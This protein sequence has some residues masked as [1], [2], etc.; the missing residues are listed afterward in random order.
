M[1]NLQN[2]TL[3]LDPNIELIRKWYQIWKEKDW[4]ERFIFLW[5]SFNALYEATTIADRD[6]D[7]WKEF[8][9]KEEVVNIW[10]TI[11]NSQEFLDF[12]RYLKNRQVY[13]KFGIELHEKGWLYNMQKNIFY[14]DW[15]FWNDLGK[16]IGVIYRIRNNLFHGWKRWDDSDID[17]IK[18]ANKSFLV[19]LEKLYWFDAN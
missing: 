19:F 16:F 11:K 6:T 1:S 13:D 2:F 9:T 15:N 10:N 5:I 14:S 12:L 8:I 4:V 18:E 3:K 7:S 17:L